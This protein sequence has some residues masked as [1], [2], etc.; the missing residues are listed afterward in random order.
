VSQTII[1]EIIERANVEISHSA[2]CL[3][4]ESDF[5]GEL[6]EPQLC[7]RDVDYQAFILAVCAFEIEN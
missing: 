3:L 7:G 5:V 2:F 4:G 6:E 1:N